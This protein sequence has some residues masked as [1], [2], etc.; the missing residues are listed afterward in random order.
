MDLVRKRKPFSDTS[1]PTVINW[2]LATAVMP[3]PSLLS[4]L[5]NVRLLST[6]VTGHRHL[7]LVGRQPH[8]KLPTLR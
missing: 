3:Q 6:I 4:S 8:N 2:T 7:Q 5:P 1:H